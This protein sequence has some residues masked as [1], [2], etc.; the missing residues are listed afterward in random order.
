MRALTRV[1][2]IASCTH[3][4]RTYRHVGA[5]KVSHND[6]PGDASKASSNAGI[7]RHLVVVACTAATVA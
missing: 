3:P 7:K 5:G 6:V 2:N 4:T 1:P